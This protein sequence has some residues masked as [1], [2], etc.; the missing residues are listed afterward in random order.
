MIPLPATRNDGR[1]ASLEARADLVV[2]TVESAAG[3]VRLH[4]GPLGEVATH[5]P[6]R[7]VPGVRFSDD[8]LEV[9]VVVALGSR[10]HVVAAT[11]ADELVAR[12]GL[13]THVRVEDIEDPVVRA[14]Y[15]PSAPDAPVAPVAPALPPHVTN[16]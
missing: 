5:F 6:G 1:D 4:P 8:S 3:V 16:S 7:R 2:R 13:R 15:V 12:I 11:L 10:V 9:H 14:P